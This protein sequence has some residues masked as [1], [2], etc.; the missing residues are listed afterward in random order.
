MNKEETENSIKL[1]QYTNYFIF[2]IR[3]YV[4]TFIKYFK[5]GVWSIR[6]Q[7]NLIARRGEDNLY[8]LRS[9]YI[10]A[11]SQTIKDLIK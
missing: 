2:H 10:T 9:K 8:K 7:T 1:L 11:A 4:K 3:Q 6:L 5:I